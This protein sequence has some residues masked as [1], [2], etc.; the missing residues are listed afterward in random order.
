MSGILIMGISTSVTNKKVGMSASD[1]K[2]SAI[3][4]Q[5]SS[6]ALCSLA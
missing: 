2:T 5:Y 1:L 6:S 4:E 3:A